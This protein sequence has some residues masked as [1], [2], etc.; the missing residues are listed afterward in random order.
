LA[1]IEVQELPEEGRQPLLEP[2]EPLRQ[3][4]AVRGALTD[5]QIRPRLGLK[6]T[7]TARPPSPTSPHPYNLNCDHL[8]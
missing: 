5:G 3:S 7:R 1:R 8:R 6:P 4:P 2:L